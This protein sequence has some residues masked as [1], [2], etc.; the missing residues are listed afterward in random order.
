ML[1]R[2]FDS[3]DTDGDGQLS[4][5][6]LSTSGGDGQHKVSPELQKVMQVAE[7]SLTE[8][9]DLFQILDAD[10]SGSVSKDEFVEGALRMRGAPQGKHLL[11]VE[12]R[13]FAMDRKVDRMG[14]A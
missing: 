14:D 13:M 3:M 12:R 2:L 8:A 10:G 7:I 9:Q 1:R 11:S 6:E 4:W 5:E